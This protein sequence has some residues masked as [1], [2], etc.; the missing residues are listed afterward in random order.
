M[1]K[2]KVFEVGAE[3]GG[4]TIWRTEENGEHLFLYKK[5]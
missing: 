2:V 5:S 1:T 3:G 4:L